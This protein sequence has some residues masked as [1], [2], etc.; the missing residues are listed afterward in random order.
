MVSHGP[1][2]Y[3]RSMYCCSF[4]Q[5][6][7]EFPKRLKSM[8]VNLDT[9][10]VVDCIGRIMISGFVQLKLDI[11]DLCKKCDPGVVDVYIS[12]SRPSFPLP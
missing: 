6:G 5:A 3:G 7:F 4:S 2:I 8:A 1:V 10:A 9:T 11:H 12:S